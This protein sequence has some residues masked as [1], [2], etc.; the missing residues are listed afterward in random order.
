[1]FEQSLA[2]CR[3]TVGEATAALTLLPEV[4]FQSASGELGGL[5]EHLDELA[6]RVD[7]ARVLITQEA[8]GRG[9]VQESTCASTTDWVL[10]HARTLGPAEAHQVSTVAAAC[11][12]PANRLLAE[13]LRDATVSTRCAAVALR[14]VARVEPFLPDEARDEALGWFL[15][16]AADAR[17]KQLRQLGT[18]LV[19]KFGGAAV[20]VQQDRLARLSSLTKASL[21]NG[22]TRYVMDLDPELSAV[23][24]AA[25]DPLAKPEPCTETGVADT[26]LAPQ[27]RAEALIEVCR[28]AAAAGGEAPAT[29]RA[30]VIVTIDLE[31]LRGRV[32]IGTTITGEHLGAETVRKLA[33][34]A[35]VLPVVL[36]GESEPLDVGRAKR[37]VSGGLLSALW[38]RDKGCTFPGCSRPPGWCHA[39]H[40]RHWVDGG[41]TSLL[42]SVLLCQRHHTI[43]H[44]RDL[45]ATVT[46][47]GVTWHT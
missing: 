42:N 15:Q 40:V 11:R 41:E 9:V 8:E 35:G 20:Q 25:I 19:G 16:V 36:G 27:R 39:H 3:D 18:W 2:G 13:A 23:L 24:D 26:R 38:V 7:A 31:A 14:E 28:R 4:I 33:C 32:G 43:V 22:L 5:L 46:T 45:T 30:Q 29:T 44:Q 12:L 47:T 34:D 10:S 21:G 1:M 6:S 37:L 17:P